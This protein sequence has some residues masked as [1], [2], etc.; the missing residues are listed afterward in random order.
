[1]TYG[2]LGHNNPPSPEEEITRALE[3]SYQDE[4]AMAES[5]LRKEADLP[6]DITDD[7]ALGVYSDYSKRLKA[8][9]KMLDG[10]R[11]TEKEV[12][13]AKANAVHNF[14]KKKIDQITDVN[15]RVGDKLA[16]YLAMKEAQKRREAEEK[17]RAER[18]EA[19]RRMREAEAKAREAEEA[20]KKAEQER[21]AAEKAAQE[22]REKAEREAKE[23]R[24]KA[25]READELR[26]K[27]EEERR[28]AAEEAARLRKEA[29][30]AREREEI[31]K[32]ESAQKLKEAEEA[33]KQAE[34]RA[35]EAEK[36]AKLT[37]EAADKAAKETLK[38]AR[39]VEKEANFA[40]FQASKD[41]K[42][43]DKEAN[44]ALDAAATA[45]RFARKA[46]RQTVAGMADF[47]R[48]RGDSSMASITEKWVG[49]VEDRAA[50]DLEALR[51]HLPFDA[52]EQ[53]VQSFV[54]AG[55]R[56]LKGAY[57]YQD[58]KAVVR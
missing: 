48:T 32:R 34:R 40:V 13:S 5:V 17:A 27:A 8:Q 1:M 39:E 38:E 47:S 24:E 28:K 42:E 2:E 6:P 51:E 37:I 58:L 33:Q 29:E 22:A 36:E 44:R 16:K 41:A 30:D 56:E 9:E 12:Y 57:I 15:A 54:N 46:E 53:A 4:I 31:S 19:E 52:L 18:E 3:Q 21:L 35:K 55:G 43:A 45:D 50:I 49:R 23:A 10:I 11:K 7:N 20:R 26:R 25:E 14:F